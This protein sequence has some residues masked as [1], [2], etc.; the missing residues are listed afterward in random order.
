MRAGPHPDTWSGGALLALA[1]GYGCLALRI[2]GADREPGPRFFP[3][4]LAVLLAIVAVQIVVSGLRARGATDLSTARGAVPM[5]A[6]WVRP[7]LAAAMTVLYAG[8]LHPLGFLPSTVAYVAG[9][10]AL[11]SSD[12]RLLLIVP[13]VV[14]LSLHLFFDVALGV[15]LP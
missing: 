6:E 12:R 8:V 7:G 4:V 2:P 13:P 1:I 3:L 5:S 11:F 10:T 14:A 9:V 15:R